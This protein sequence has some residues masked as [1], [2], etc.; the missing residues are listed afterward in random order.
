MTF[1]L[2]ASQ[3]PTTRPRPEQPEEGDVMPHPIHAHCTHCGRELLLRELTINHSA[4]CPTCGNLLAP[5]YSFMLLDEARRA[6]ALAGELAASLQ[7]LAALP[8]RLVL[9]RD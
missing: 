9:D 7:R 4:T 2:Q 6:E 1:S 5:N 3:P 8:G